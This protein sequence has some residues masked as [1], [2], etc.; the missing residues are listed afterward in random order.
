MVSR[1][2]FCQRFAA[3][4]GG[5]PTS[6]RNG[7]ARAGDVGRARVPVVAGRVQL[8]EKG[9]LVC[10]EEVGSLKTQSRRRWREGSSSSVTVS[11]NAM[12]A[13]LEEEPAAKGEARVI[14]EV[15]G[16]R[17]VV[18]DTRQEILNGVDLVIREGEVSLISS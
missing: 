9:V 5:L 15:Q 17:A 12:S 8:R 11:T 13:Q 3:G 14:L 4:V 1:S 18:A 2:S 10:G 6:I 7:A 16:L